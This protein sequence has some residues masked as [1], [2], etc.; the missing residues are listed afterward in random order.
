MARRFIVR[1]S[2]DFSRI[3]F[4]GPSC[5]AR[6]R[7]L[8]FFFKGSF[9]FY[10]K[11]VF[12]PVLS[13]CMILAEITFCTSVNLEQPVMV[14]VLFFLTYQLSCGM[15]YLNL[16]V[17]YEFT[18]FKRESRTTFCTAAFLCNEYM[19]KYYVFS[20]YL[21]M[22]YILAVNVMSRRY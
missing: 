6:G 17:S 18:G 8:L 19:F 10:E 13:L 12:S 14:L 4:L 3:L 1:R 9:C 11:Y 2:L 21:Y 20:T 5:R 15:R 16:S 22:L 7:N